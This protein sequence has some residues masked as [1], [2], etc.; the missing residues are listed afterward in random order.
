MMTIVRTGEQRRTV[1]YEPARRLLCAFGERSELI[2]RQIIL[3]GI[4]AATL[5]Y[6]SSARGIKNI[7]V[8][9]YFFRTGRHEVVLIAGGWIFL[10]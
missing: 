2:F 6:G 7:Y 8:H 5:N 9:S 10:K 3:M 1:V 4:S